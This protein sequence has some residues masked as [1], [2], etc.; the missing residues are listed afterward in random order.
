MKSIVKLLLFTVTVSLTVSFTVA[1][2]QP[3]KEILKV[4][5]MRTC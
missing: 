1:L 4:F 2:A 3:S 5:W